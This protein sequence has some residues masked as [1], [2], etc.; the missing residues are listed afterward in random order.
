MPDLQYQSKKLHVVQY[1]MEQRDV[2]DATEI[3]LPE[4]IKVIQEK[5]RKV[6]EAPLP[7]ARA[8]PHRHRARPPAYRRARP[9]RRMTGAWTRW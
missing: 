5:R 4:R 7:A 2:E 1:A 9:P 8:A 6:S 3:C